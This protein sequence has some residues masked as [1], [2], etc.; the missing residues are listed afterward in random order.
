MRKRYRVIQHPI[1]TEKSTRLQEERNQYAFA[2]E[3]TA[4]KREIAD[5][6]EKLFGVSVL[7]V[8]TQ[9][10]M[11]KMRRLGRFTG[12]RADWK[13]A[14]VTLAQGDAIELYENV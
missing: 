6:I 5:A 11:G 2:V 14:I 7:R 10:H 12:R 8:R 4:T 3:P 1:F 13:K 9:N